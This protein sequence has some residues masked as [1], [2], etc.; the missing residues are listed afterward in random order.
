MCA[1]GENQCSVSICHNFIRSIG[2]KFFRIIIDIL[3]GLNGEA[4]Q[5]WTEIYNKTKR[6]RRTGTDEIEHFYCFQ[7]II[8]DL[9][10]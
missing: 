9:Q 8:E 7:M 2:L 6:K 10:F 1:S 3:G 4:F 5:L